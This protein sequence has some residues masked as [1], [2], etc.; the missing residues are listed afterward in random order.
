MA[1]SGA[2]LLPCGVTHEVLDKAY[3]TMYHTYEAQARET[4]FFN[5]LEKARRYLRRWPEPYKYPET[6]LWFVGDHEANVKAIKHGSPCMG[7]DVDPDK[8]I[9][10]CQKYHHWKAGKNYPTCAEIQ[11]IRLW[12]QCLLLKEETTQ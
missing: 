9:C 1:T 7:Y 11:V 6:N 3:D 8:G 10:A 5:G 2:E 12:Q 4:I